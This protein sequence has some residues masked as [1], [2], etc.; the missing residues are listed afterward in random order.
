MWNWDEDKRRANRAKHGV[1]FDGFDW[2][3]CTHAT[4]DRFN[5]G[6][7]RIVLAGTIA[8]RLHLVVWTPRG[9]VRRI[10]SLRKTNDR[11]EKAYRFARAAD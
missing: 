3:T 5:H 4:N 6:E 7:P 8:G 11:E 10:I 2:E 9:P 1:D